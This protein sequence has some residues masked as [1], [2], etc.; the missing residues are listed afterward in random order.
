MNVSVVTY[1]KYHGRG[2]GSAGSSMIRGKWLV[3]KWPEAKL[4]TNGQK[5]DAM[6]FQKAYW[7][8]MMEDFPGKKILDLCDPDWM[9][10]DL[11]LEELA[12]CVD[13]ITCSNQALTDFV[14][15]AVPGKRVETV[16]DRLNLDYFQTKKEHKGKATKVVYFGFQQNANVVLPFALPALARMGMELL[17]VSNRPYSGYTSYGVPI[18]FVKWESA[19]AYQDIQT[20]D[21]AINPPV[22]TSNFRFKSNNKTLVAWGLGLP[23]ANTADELERFTDPAER[24]KEAAMRWEELQHD[25]R[26]EQSVEQFKQILAN[27]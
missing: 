11:K 26:I 7:K 1:E 10:G 23:V 2:E 19:T 16:P 14:S 21:I 15:Q 4:W 12:A 13:A 8:L 3:D 5:A 20:A 24:T 17:L 6:I 25:W 9:G 27:I 18:K 22:A